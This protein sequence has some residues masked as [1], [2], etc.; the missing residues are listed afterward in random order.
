MN[1]QADLLLHSD[2]ARY[3]DHDIIP[4]FVDDFACGNAIGVGFRS[5]NDWWKVTGVKIDDESKLAEVMPLS[6][7]RASSSAAN[8]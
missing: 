2:I 4:T 8:F 6:K 7:Y 3:T 5:Y 1:L